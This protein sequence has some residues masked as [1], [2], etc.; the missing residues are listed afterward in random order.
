MYYVSRLLYYY[1]L[2]ILVPGKHVSVEP[3]AL[4]AV[5]AVTNFPLVH[6]YLSD[7]KSIIILAVLI[8]RIIY[9]QF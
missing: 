6:K 4:S 2:C 5:Y 8:E 7:D 9:N 3:S 1:N